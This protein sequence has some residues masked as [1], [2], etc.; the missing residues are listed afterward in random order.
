LG[1]RSSQLKSRPQR[2]ESAA[3]RVP[4]DPTAHN[5]LGNALLARGRRAEALT[6]F[7]RALALEPDYAAA[8]NN[9]GVAL[10]ELGRLED[11]VA[12]YDRA[13]ALKPDHASAHNNRG[14]ALQ[15][16][17]RLKRAIESYDRALAVRADYAEA[18][19]NRGSALLQLQRFEEALASVDRALALDPGRAAAHSNRGLALMELGRL[20]EALV[21]FER[22][23][24]LQPAHSRAHDNRGAAL[25]ACR[26][27]EDARA[28][29][30]RALALEPESAEALLNLG[31]ALHGLHRFSEALAS[32]DRAIALRSDYAD[33]HRNRGLALLGLGQPEEAVASYQ[34]ALELEPSNA[35]VRGVCRH[36]QMQICDWSGYE[37]DLARLAGAIERGRCVVRPFAA[38]SLFD[39]P[40]LQRRVAGIWARENCRPAQRLG[41]L[42]RHR[43]HQKVRVGYFS[44][45]FRNHAV[46]L[47]AAELFERHDRSRFELTAFA[48]GPDVRDE[49]R[50]RIEAAFDRFIPVFDR[51][52]AEVAALA[53]HLEIDIAVDL[54]GYTQ[55]ARPCIFAQRAAPIQ[56]G[57]LG[58]LGTMGADFM[59]YLIADEVIVPAEQRRHYAEKIAYLSS[60][61]VNDSKRPVAAHA[62]SRAELGLPPAGF[63]FCCFN[64]NYKINPET[65]A[66]WMRILE[67]VPGSVLFLLGSSPA[68]E[69]N[70]RQQAAA[71]G[72]APQRLVFG[73]KLP[74]ADYLARYR[75]AD[76]FLDTLP[77]N[78]GTTASDALWVGLP[79]LTCSGEAFAARIGASLL[80][81]V[82]LPELIAV[83]RSHYERLAVE[84]ATRPGALAAIRRKLEEMH[85]G[86]ALFDTTRFTGE[87]EALYERMYRRHHLGLLP[88]HLAPEPAHRTQPPS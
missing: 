37:I 46:S 17:G 55:D 22:A 81:A 49:L 26:R 85:S 38:L 42:R 83:D 15:K 7:D 84:L 63:V 12:S 74:Y 11:A 71:G 19:D 24:T 79:V 61:Q 21:S 64:A 29:H 70:L 77:Y 50:T 53:R 36:A 56:V 78:A 9:R 31:A 68:A 67:A 76:L 4:N 75:A 3:A 62:F 86:A 47:L 66:S 43:W 59:D 73:G 6:C 44:A 41:A 39:S 80:T 72:L 23:I 16:L 88:E 5:D 32:F 10:Q 27:F 14:T 30:E 65:F 45:D 48:L 69:R 28:S 35:F 57:Y 20:D 54:G 8:C 1:R 34:R 33:A 52:D 13:L 51:A 2:L 87:L 82:G 18:H 58:Y 40:G 60:Y 25:A